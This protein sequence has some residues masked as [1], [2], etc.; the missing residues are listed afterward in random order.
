MAAAGRHFC[1]AGCRVVHDLL[2]ESGL[3]NYYELQRHPGVRA[4]RRDPARRWA[5]LDEPEVAAKLLDF[6]DGRTSRVTFQLPAI[7]CVACV[8]LLENLFRLHPG[9]GTVRV[10]FA[11]R[12]ASFAFSNDRLTLSGLVALLVSLGYEPVLTLDRL[13]G[14]PQRARRHRQWIQIAVAGFAFGN[15]MLFSLPAYLGLDIWTAPLFRAVFGWIS[16]ALAFPVVVYSASDYWKSAALSIRR[17]RLTLDVPIAL[18]LGALYVQSAWSIVVQRGDGY[19]DS[20]AGLVFFLLCGR[21]FQQTTQ[22]RFAFDRDYRSFFPISVARRLPGG[23]REEHV[24]LERLK[25]GDRLVLR[26]GELIPADARLASDAALIDYSFVT[27]ESEPL[28]KSRGDY[29]YAG[30]K[31]IGGAIELET[32]KPVSHSYLTS[33]WNHEAFRKTR[34]AG[35]ESL[36]N[37]F[38]LA[39]TIAVICLAAGAAV[40][41]LASGDSARAAKAFTS[42]LIVAC[43]CALALAAPFTLGTAQRLFARA[44]VFVRNVDVIE[45]MARIDSVVFDK[46]GTLTTASVGGVRFHGPALSR[47]DEQR[48]FSLALQSSHPHASRIANFLSAHCL[49]DPVQDFRETAG[50]GVEGRVHGRS[51]L[52][53]SPAW[54]LSRGIAVQ[55]LP[56]RPGSLVA[57]AVDGEFQGAF[58]IANDMRPEADQMTM[59]L[60]GRMEVSLVSGDNPREA[61]RFR[62]LM[63]PGAPLLFNQ[64][65]LDKLHYVRDRQRAGRTVMMV[66]DGLNDA[67]AFRQSDVGVAVVERAGAF[68]PASDVILDATRVAHLGRILAVARRSATIVRVGF[69][70]SALYNLAGISVAAAGLLS[71]LVSA[72]LMPLSSFSV[73]L[74]ACGV[75]RLAG[76]GL[77][78]RADAGEEGGA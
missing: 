68:S 32:V 4:F 15:I 54:L 63:G 52:L 75:T 72:I 66:G 40:F 14:A 5:F 37:R 13:D 64:S 61:D 65:P 10:N 30:G 38:S 36:T 58:V 24:S 71:P 35:F 60:A 21:A 7:H 22:E 42:I 19:L 1:C 29:L 33:L 78:C 70:I 31:Q 3:G 8:W 76:R 59:D 9:V 25:V 48:V 26:H 45:E 18:G 56:N 12:E 43:P 50:C 55:S 73:V 41:W 57:L 53:G 20:L 67:G 17:R 28:P 27:G 74:F 6:T 16:L 11:R 49:L 46:T 47:P 39:F 44:G 69:G 34:K 2:T 51:L 23:G 77:E 62:K